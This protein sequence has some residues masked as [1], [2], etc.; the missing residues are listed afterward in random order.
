MFNFDGELIRIFY[1][2]EFIVFD[3]FGY[4]VVLDVDYNWV[5]IGVFGKDIGKVDSGFVYLFDFDG[6]KI[7]I[8]WNLNFIVNFEK[9]GI[10]VVVNGNNVLIGV[11]NK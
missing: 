2:F 1:S 9:F 10:S 3:Y 6:K 8:F 5:L 4:S 7:K 11:E